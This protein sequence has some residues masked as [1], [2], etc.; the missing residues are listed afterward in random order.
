MF[1][2]KRHLHHSEDDPL[3]VF[4]IVRIAHQ[5]VQRVET[6]RREQVVEAR[7]EVLLTHPLSDVIDV[8]RRRRAG[9]RTVHWLCRFSKPENAFFIGVT[10][11]HWH[12][13]QLFVSPQTVVFVARNG[14]RVKS[15]RHTNCSLRQENK[16]PNVKS[17]LFS[18]TC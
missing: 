11:A 15:F 9:Q 1:T 2:V 17:I 3:V 4:V 10:Q 5:D 7:D 16:S 6:I 18:Q 13:Q 14:A 8:Q 12:T